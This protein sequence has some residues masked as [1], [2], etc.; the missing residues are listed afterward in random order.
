MTKTNQYLQ[1]EQE[2]ALTPEEHLEAIL[3]Q[4]VNLYERWSEDRQVTAKQSSDMAKFVKEFAQQVNQFANLEEKVRDDIHTSIRREAENTAVY[5]SK[6]IGEA[7]K[8]EIAPTVDKLRAASN[9]ASHVLSRYQSSMGWESWKM[10]AVSV[11]SSVFLALLIVFFCMPKPAIPITDQ[12]LEYLKF[13][14]SMRYVWPKLS[15]AEQERIKKL[16]AD[17]HKAQIG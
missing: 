11:A 17:V 7:A 12:Q 4:F 14:E 15:K 6:T 3:F 9:D 1:A 10:V 16:A 2:E 5:F 8:K 13:G